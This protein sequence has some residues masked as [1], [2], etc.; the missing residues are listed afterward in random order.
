MKFKL[1][2]LLA[3]IRQKS[4]LT[5]NLRWIEEPDSIFCYERTLMLYFDRMAYDITV[6]VNSVSIVCWNSCGDKLAKKHS[7][8]FE[9]AH[10]ISNFFSATLL[11]SSLS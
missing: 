4:S 9:G 2:I 11:C 7:L 1:N 10:A 8:H 3:S 5:Y 6:R